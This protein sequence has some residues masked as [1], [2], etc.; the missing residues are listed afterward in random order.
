MTLTLTGVLHLVAP[1]PF[2]RLIP[3]RL[4]GTA[5]AWAVG[6]GYAELVTAGLLLAP[7]TRRLGGVVAAALFLG[8]WPGNVK[9]AWDWR[10]E[11]LL[12]QLV[13]VGRLPLQIP[14]IGSAVRIAR[15]AS[16]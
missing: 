3:R 13:S 2:E 7:A 5:R 4:P 1:R 14:M 8:V 11:S 6:S 16:V 9:M 12:R 10:H 15:Y